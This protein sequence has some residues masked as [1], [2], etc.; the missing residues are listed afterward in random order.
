MASFTTP[1]A[2][3]ASS[4]FTPDRLVVSIEDAL[5]K[6]VTVPSGTAAMVRGT[7]LGKITIGTAASA[8][9][10][11]GNTGT[12]TCVMDGT[13]P[14]LTSARVGIYTLR[15]TVAST[16]AATFRLVD[17]TGRVLGDYAF[18]GSG[19][20]VTIANQIKC[21]VTDGGTD[22]AVGDGFDITVAAGSGNYIKAVSTATDGSAD[23]DAIL[24]A[25]VD[26]SGGA[27]EALAYYAGFFNPSAMTFGSGITAASAFEVLREKG[28]MLVPAPIPAAF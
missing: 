28:I 14:V 15:C 9:K 3:F 25:D 26:A 2:S 10:S 21:A 8:A 18:S 6:K 22:F 5:S 16:N 23:P 24:V 19:A 7:L 1:L 27:K 12:G 17:P 13:T 11:G 4:N 20:S